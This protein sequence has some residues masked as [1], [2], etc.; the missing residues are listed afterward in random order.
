[1][2]LY[3]MTTK[4]LANR[5]DQIEDMGDGKPGEHRS[6][7]LELERRASALVSDM[8]LEQYTRSLSIGYTQVTVEYE[9]AMGWK[10]N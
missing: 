8:T 9:D 10:Y 6:I 3:D 4:A 2:N 7:V 1:M 5:R